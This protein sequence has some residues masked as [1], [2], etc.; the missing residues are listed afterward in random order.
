[1]NTFLLNSG[2]IC[3]VPV[4]LAK[5][6]TFMNLSGES[7]STIVY[8]DFLNIYISFLDDVR[9]DTYCRLDHWCR[10]SIYL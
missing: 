10:T 8:T 6:T 9:L 3:D 5:P 7:V 1:M 4:M 2:C